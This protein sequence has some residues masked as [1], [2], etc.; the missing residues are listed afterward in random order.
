[1]LAIAF[2]AALLS[3]A[4]THPFSVQDML[5]MERVAEP[6]VSPDGKRVVFAV[7][8]TD[9]GANRRRSELYLVGSDGT[10]LARLTSHD[11]GSDSSPAWAPD[12]KSVYFLASRSGTSQVWRI[13]TEGGEAEAVTSLPVDVN[14]F[15][16]SPD[17]RMLVVSLDVFVDCDTL[18][19]TK[20]RLDEQAARKA[21]GRVYD[22]L[23]VRHW[24]SWSDGRRAHLWVLPISG[25]EP[26]ELMK[27]MDADATS[28]PWGGPE[29]LAFTRDGTALVFTARHAGREEAWSTNFDLFVAPLDG[30]SAPRNLTASNAAWDTQPA[31][32]PDG[33]TLA[34][35]AMKV[36]GYEADRYRIVLKSWPAGQE[37]V[38]TEAWDRS[39]SSLLWSADGKTLYALADDLGQVAIFAVNAQSGEV[40]RVFGDGMAKGLGLAGER[41]IF[42][43]EHLRSPAELFSVKRDGSD[44]KALTR[45]NA[46]RVAAADMG[47][48]TQFSFLGWNNET[49]WGYIVK[50]ARFDASKK[51]PVALLIHGGPQQS[52][53]N[54]FHYRWNPQAYAGAGFGVVVIDFHGSTGYGQAFSD[55]IQGDWGGK[56][57][58]DLQKGLAAAVE[59]SP[60]M[61]GARACAL[62]ASYGGYMI[63]WIAGNWP[64][65]F[66]C[67]VA[68]DG[69]LDERAAYFD[70]EELWFPEHDHK[71]TPWSNPAGYDVHNPVNYVG[72]WKTPMLVVHGG[73]DYRV[74]DTQG[75]SSFNALQRRGI[76]SKF[77]YFPDENH[78]VLKP[79]N[80]ILW[81]ETVLGWLKQW[82]AAD[83]AAP[84]AGN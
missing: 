72:N 62:G 23:F 59:R 12:G 42:A 35:L 3:T 84:V 10:G 55:A 51:Y 46:A 30:K 14:A 50:P 27:G 9:L 60:W 73:R 43:R 45:I 75:L 5:A 66:R 22:H 71:G 36:P 69:N 81:H 70:T 8:R 74:V 52:F 28:K 16:L 29:E 34:Y 41:L 67:L 54:D 83:G 39:P 19:C 6:Q 40:R 76:P 68:H 26:Q 33:K 82:T 4:E 58:V 7:S 37:R 15:L 56:P 1:M 44:I 38:L 61:D 24:D 25:G 18:A 63:N 47:E 77:L 78:W 31:F 57:L 79:A 48:P 20:Q 2:V 32:S 53:G 49:V 21:T 65:R 11:S 13:R 64:E 17:G 80:S